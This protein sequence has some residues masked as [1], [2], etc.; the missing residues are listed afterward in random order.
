MMRRCISVHWSDGIHL[1]RFDEFQDLHYLGGLRRHLLDLF[2]FDDYV[3][4]F[5]VLKAFDDF[6]ARD[7]LVLGLAVDHLLDARSVGLV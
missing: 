5:F 2:V 1:F 7:G 4:I 3:A 6:A